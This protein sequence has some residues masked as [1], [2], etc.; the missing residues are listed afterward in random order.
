MK[1][2]VMAQISVPGLHSWSNCNI[3]SVSFLKDLHRHIF[4]IKVTLEVF[5]D[6]REIEFFVLQNKIKNAIKTRF[7]TSTFDLYNFENNSCEMIAS[8]LCE[9]FINIYCYSKNRDIK[10]EVMEDGENG[11][12]VVYEKE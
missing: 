7:V 8:F 2:Y 3:E 10:V 5:D 12:I 11:G 6:D 1:K 4:I 9:K